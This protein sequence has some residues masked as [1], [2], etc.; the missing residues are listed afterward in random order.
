MT[1]TDVT[2]PELRLDCGACL[3]DVVQHVE[4]AG[5][6]RRDDPILVLHALTGSARVREWWPAIA[7]APGALFDPQRWC[8][9][10]INALGSCYG[11]SGPR[12]AADFAPITVADMV[13]AQALA[14]ER[15]GFSRFA[16]A[17][18]GSLGGMQALQWA[19]DFPERVGHAIVVAAHDHHSAMGVAL[20]GLQREAIALDSVRGLRLARK[21]AV[22]TYKS[23]ALLAA[24]H[25]RR[26]DRHGRAGFDVEGYLEAQAER[27]VGRMD[28]STYAVLTSAMD[29]FDVRRHR[30]RATPPPIDFVGISGDWLFRPADVRAAAARLAARECSSAYTEFESDHGHDAFLAEAPR[31]AQLLRAILARRD[32]CSGA[33]VKPAPDGRGDQIVLDRMQVR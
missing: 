18:G 4:I 19:L 20:N 23:D 3:H 25:D 10:G 31:L 6:P 27:F 33:F 1:A 5:D 8:V 29:S 28:A 13:R 11:S 14:L 32:A 12:D 21:L 15:L 22:L 30:P 16:L 17:I 2:L 24:R 26:P 7:G 9:V